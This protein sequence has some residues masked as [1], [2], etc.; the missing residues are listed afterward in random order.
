VGR[1]GREESRRRR[2]QPCSAEEGTT[3]RPGCRCGGRPLDLLGPSELQ[4]QPRPTSHADELRPRGRA[5][6]V[7][8]STALELVAGSLERGRLVPPVEVVRHAG[9]GRLMRIWAGRATPQ[10]PTSPPVISRPGRRDACSSSGILRPHR[11]RCRQ[12]EP[13]R[14]GGDARLLFPRAGQP[15]RA[16]PRRN[17]TPP[18]RLPSGRPA[19]TPRRTRCRALPLLEAPREIGSAG[20]ESGGGSKR[21]EMGGGQ[22]G[23]WV[24][25]KEKKL[26][27]WAHVVVV[28]ME[29]EI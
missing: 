19:S 18:P 13:S 28:C 10:C 23:G 1:K 5:V 16:P 3:Q 24:L 21:E 26:L 14:A 17:S 12:D 7:A 9:E 15:P 29:Y 27:E 4:P 8:S 22:G 6:E 25:K 11:W 2:R 20:E